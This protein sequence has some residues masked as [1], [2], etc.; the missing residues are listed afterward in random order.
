MSLAAALAI[1][2]VTQQTGSGPAPV[3]QRALY[4]TGAID[5]MGYRILTEASDLVRGFMR[6]QSIQPCSA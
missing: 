4:K 2:T 3:R 1:H 5:V 6:A